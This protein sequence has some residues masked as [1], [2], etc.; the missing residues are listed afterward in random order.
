MVVVRLE[1][2]VDPEPTKFAE[3][4]PGKRGS[5]ICTLPKFE[6][7]KFRSIVKYS[8]DHQSDIL[9]APANEP[10]KSNDVLRDLQ[11]ASES[12]YQLTGKT[13]M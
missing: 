1:V 12:V 3:L 4:D 11:K 8:T 13:T 9:F 7:W 2:G 5:V 6:T 10:S